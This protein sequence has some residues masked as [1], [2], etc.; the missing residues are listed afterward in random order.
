[1][2]E[3]I[4]NIINKMDLIENTR[5]RIIAGVYLKEWQRMLSVMK[6]KLLGTINIPVGSYDGFGDAI[7]FIR[8]GDPM[9][10]CDKVIYYKD[11]PD[12]FETFKLN[13]VYDTLRVVIS[14]DWKVCWGDFSEPVNG[15]LKT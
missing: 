3:D 1:M 4:I 15:V 7:L 10:M 8:K 9:L 6:A 12:N 13:D 11:H 2:Y 14:D 5:E